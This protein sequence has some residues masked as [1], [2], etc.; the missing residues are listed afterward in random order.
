MLNKKSRHKENKK[1]LLEFPD[2]ESHG[3]A[4]VAPLAPGMNEGFT[5]VPKM[6]SAWSTLQWKR[7]RSRSGLFNSGP[8]FFGL[9]N[10][11]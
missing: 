1:C 6:A 2:E 8:L 4:I 3:G 9:F 11:P 10:G 7:D 5:L